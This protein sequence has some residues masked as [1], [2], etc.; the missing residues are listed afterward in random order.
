MFHVYFKFKQV[1]WI[2]LAVNGILTGSAPG[3]A[4]YDMVDSEKV[5]AVKKAMLCEL[6]S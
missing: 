1:E 3:S 4:G 2:V 5:L 6:G